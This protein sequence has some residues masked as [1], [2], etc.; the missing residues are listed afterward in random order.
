MIIEPNKAKEYMSL[1]DEGLQ[2]QQAGIDVS[3]AEI[4]VFKSSGK[5]DFDNSDRKRADI[6]ALP[7]PED[8]TLKLSPGPYLVTLNE[9]FKMPRDAAAIMRPRSTLSRCGA[10]IATSV[11]DP[12]YEGRSQ[13]LLIVFN[14]HGLEIKKDARIGQILFFKMDRPAK[15]LYRGAYHKENLQ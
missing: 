5:I 9:T 3:V 4:A 14:E 6:E 15:S 12:G 2:V 10:T 7:W 13:V 11:W 8:K 1:L